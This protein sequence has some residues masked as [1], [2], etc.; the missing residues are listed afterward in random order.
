[1]SAHQGVFGEWLA[2]SGI[3]PDHWRL[4]DSESKLAALQK[5]KDGATPSPVLAVAF[6][7]IL[8]DS[9]FSPIDRL[10]RSKP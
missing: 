5:W 2:E 1:V 4:L 10:Y 6:R 3:S 7:S 8:G 9:H